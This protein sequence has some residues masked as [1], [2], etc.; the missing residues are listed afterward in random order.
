MTENNTTVAT[1]ARG[2][3]VGSEYTLAHV[4]ACPVKSVVQQRMSFRIR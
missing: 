2:A 3:P 4:A 1:G